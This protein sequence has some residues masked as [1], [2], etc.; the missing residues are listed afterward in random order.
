M[1]H[2]THGNIWIYAELQSLLESLIES[3]KFK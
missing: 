1:L 3:H 2:L